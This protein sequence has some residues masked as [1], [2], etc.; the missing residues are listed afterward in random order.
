M[1]MGLSSGRVGLECRLGFFRRKRVDGLP[2]EILALLAL[3]ALVAGFV[4]AIAGGGGLLT[5]PALLWAGLPPAVALGTNKLQGTFGTASATA[6]FL[7]RGKLELRPLL[8]AAAASFAGSA[9]GSLLVS[10]IDPDALRWLLPALLLAFAAYFLRSPRVG[11]LPSRRRVGP[12]AFAATAGVGIGFYDGFFGP[13]TG[14]FFALAFVALLGLDLAHATGGA[15]L[16]NFASNLAA[17]L[18]F[19]AGGHVLWPVGLVMAVGQW[20][21]AWLGAHMAIRHGARLIRPLLVAVSAVLSV[22]LLVEQL[23]A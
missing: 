5:L 9:G 20:L 3:V 19:A 15:K 2:P 13:G 16:L 8:P 23:G 6:H 10:R 22:K 11:D 14:S 17:L 1:S 18:V 4:D 7:R 21:G 12:A